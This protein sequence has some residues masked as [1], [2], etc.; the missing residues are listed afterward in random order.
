MKRPRNNLQKQLEWLQQGEYDPHAV[1]RSAAP[2]PD[3]TESSQLIAVKSSSSVNHDPLSSHKIVAQDKEGKVFKENSVKI[4]TN[5]FISKE[6]SS[7]GKT[8]YLSDNR[9]AVKKV[10]GNTEGSF[11][12]SVVL[13]ENRDAFKKIDGNIEGD[14]RKHADLDLKSL[15]GE[16]KKSNHFQLDSAS[17]S[18]YEE[19]LREIFRLLSSSQFGSDQYKYFRKRQ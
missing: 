3:Q 4:K 10:G 13:T 18:K 2:L 5:D 11:G 16:C 9:D 1:F 8:M 15:E 14:V 12:K 17:R 19:E 6:K 7:F